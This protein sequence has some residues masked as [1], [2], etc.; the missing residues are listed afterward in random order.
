MIKINKEIYLKHT[1]IDLET[2]NESSSTYLPMLGNY[3]CD[4]DFKNFSPL[5]SDVPLTQNYEII[6]QEKFPTTTEETL[7]CQGPAL[8]ITEQ[9]GEKGKW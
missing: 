6:F 4:S 1:V 3:L 9:V 8:E 7:F 2:L 5:A